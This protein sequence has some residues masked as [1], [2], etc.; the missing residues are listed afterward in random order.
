MK[1]MIK[2]IQGRLSNLDNIS[3]IIETNASIGCFYP[4]EDDYVTLANYATEKDAEIALNMLQNSLCDC[5]NK[6]C[7]VVIVDVPTQ[8][9]VNN[10]KF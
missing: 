6:V 1:I 5:N 9:D 8:L 7:N 2:D 4:G 10:F 3:M